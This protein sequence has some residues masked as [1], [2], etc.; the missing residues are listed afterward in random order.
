MSCH[1]SPTYHGICIYGLRIYH[2]DHANIYPYHITLIS[3]SH[4]TKWRAK[5]E[6]T[7]CHPILQDTDV[8]RYI[9][10]ISRDMCL[11]PTYISLRPCQNV[12]LSYHTNITIVFIKMAGQSRNYNLP[13][14]FA[15]YRFKAICHRHITGYVSMVYVYITTT[16]PTYIP[17][18][19]L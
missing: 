13:S 11:W 2:Y 16:M 10:E 5:A 18:I 15:R 4:S 3:R 8:W 14:P 1:I 19:S 6:I 9:T 7:I 17:I 12:S